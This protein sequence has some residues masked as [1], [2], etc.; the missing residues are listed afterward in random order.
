MIASLG[1]IIYQNV[2]GGVDVGQYVIYSRKSKFT[3]QGESVEN[4]IG[5]CRR[6]IAANFGE[7]EAER[8][9]VYEDEGFSGG[10]LERPQFRQ[11]MRDSHTGGFTA[12]V[13]Y[14]LDRIS[15]NIGDFAKLIDDLG[16]RGIG[17]ISIKEQ[18]DTSSPM[19]RAMMYIASV[20]SQLERET[21]AERIRD[22]M[23][24]LS[25]TGRWL[26][27][28]TPLGFESESFTIPGRDGRARRAC[29]LR[30]VPEEMALVRF[31]FGCFLETGSLK[32]TCAELRRRGC[33]TRRGRDFSRF[34][35]R[36]ILSNP[37][38]SA[39][40]EAAYG[41]FMSNGAQVCPP[42]ERFDGGHGVMAYD[43]TLQRPGKTHELRGMDEWI[44]AVGE[45]PAVIP[46]ARWAEVQHMLELNRTKSCRRP[47][48]GT[49]LLSGLIFCAECGAPMRAKLGSGRGEER[50]FAYICTAKERS[51]GSDCRM[52]N[53]RGA[54]LDGAVMS[55][56]FSIGED[57]ARFAS[58]VCRSGL[59]AGEA[60]TMRG[61]IAENEEAMRAL[62]ASIAGCRDSAAARYVIDEIERLDSATETMR[63]CLAGSGDTGAELTLTQAAQISTPEERRRL[64]RAA[65]SRVTWDG[66]TAHIYL[67]E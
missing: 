43:R 55:A 13:V 26:G 22:N 12:V 49:A 38:Y 11:M 52:K 60:E 30:I 48:T 19:G 16:G 27:G 63:L 66:E 64:V 7:A 6:Y 2:C 37:V 56:L 34:A 23:R 8:A 5:L 46:G 21:I 45:H 50:P 20:F 62:A 44:I 39:A 32:D 40:D 59:S 1:N 29:R 25:R 47:R 31:I 61:R 15:R 54:E 4:Q 33:R 17:F 14:R 65:V 18:F 36:G 67:A 57:A 24:E 51:R 10:T 35:V 3:G 41:Y 53:A 58:A 42:R 28:T 9:L